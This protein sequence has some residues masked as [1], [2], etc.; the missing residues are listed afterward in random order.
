MSA[1]HIGSVQEFREIIRS[2]SPV[3]VFFHCVHWSGPCQ[4][5]TPVFDKCSSLPELR[6]L[7][8]YKVDCD[9]QPDISSYC[10]ITNTPVFSVYQNGIKLHEV[11]GSHKS[12]LQGILKKYLR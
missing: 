3:I 6:A 11:V 5:I 9:H 2:A 8:F 12:G 10:Q 1:Q 4:Q 7:R